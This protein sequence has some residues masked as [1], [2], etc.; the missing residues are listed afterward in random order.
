VYC[1]EKLY[2][3]QNSV[4]ERHRHRYEV[5]P[6]V[7]PQLSN[8]GLLFVGMGVDETNP[9]QE[10]VPPVAKPRQLT[11]IKM[12]ISDSSAALVRMAESEP[13]SSVEQLLQ[14]IKHLCIRTGNDGAHETTAV[15]MEMLELKGVDKFLNESCLIV[16]SESQV[17]Y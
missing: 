11:N 8:A 15:R 14:K 16:G 13:G 1:L 10:N 2:G 12:G 17:C 6:A 7:V 9:N 5:N 4:E 3:E